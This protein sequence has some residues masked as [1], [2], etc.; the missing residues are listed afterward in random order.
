MKRWRVPAA[1][2]LAAIVLVAIYLVAF[3]QP[4]TSRIAALAGE[5]DQLRAQQAPLRRSIDALMKVEE[6]EPEFKT[7]LQLLEKLIPSRLAQPDL[8][9][10]MQSAAQGA[11]VELVSVTFGAPKKPEGGP[12]SPVSG[13]V[14]V[15]MPV[16]VVV[17]G[18]FA[19]VTD[20]LR[21]IEVGKERAVLVGAV[22]LA[23]AD[24][25]FPQLT[26]TWTGQAYALLPATDPLVVDPHAPIATATTTTKPEKP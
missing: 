14:L 18:P 22:A 17:N 13:T 7:A 23:E 1:G 6:R 10:E 15:T 3:H 12:P 2:A 11:G 25:G 4:R 5:A 21:R 16:T 20:M 8:L 19:G 26:G 24:S 9:A